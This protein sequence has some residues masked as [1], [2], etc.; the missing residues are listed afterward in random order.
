M[1]LWSFCLL[2]CGVFF[3]SWNLVAQESYNGLGSLSDDEIQSQPYSSNDLSQKTRL[4]FLEEQTTLLGPYVDCAQAFVEQINKNLT[5]CG[6]TIMKPILYPITPADWVIIN[7]RGVILAYFKHKRVY[8][9][10]VFTYKNPN[11]SYPHDIIA[12]SDSIKFVTPYFG[13]VAKA[14]SVATINGQQTMFRCGPY[15]LNQPNAEEA[16]EQCAH[17]NFVNLIVAQLCRFAY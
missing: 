4:C 11:G 9:Y 12:S 2:I 17:F 15:Q 5:A 10:D 8:T 3:L 14:Y 13:T 7:Q 6:L 16:F 1:K